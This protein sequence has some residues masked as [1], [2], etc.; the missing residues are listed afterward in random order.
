MNEVPSNLIDIRLWAWI[1]KKFPKN[2]KISARGN[3]NR[4]YIKPYLKEELN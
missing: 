4:C 1:Q 3:G 2:S